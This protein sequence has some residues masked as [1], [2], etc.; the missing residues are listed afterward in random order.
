MGTQLTECVEEI[1][2]GRWPVPLG[3]IF[4][5]Y[6]DVDRGQSI[7]VELVQSYPPWL[8]NSAAVHRACSYVLSGRPKVFIPVQDGDCFGEEDGSI[9]DVHGSTCHDLSV[10]HCLWCLMVLIGVVAIAEE[11]LRSGSVGSV[12]DLGT[13]GKSCQFALFCRSCTHRYCVY[14]FRQPQ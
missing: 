4:E 3:D 8:L 9:V 6:N 7:F 2:L 10:F 14:S 11:E 12:G 1:P 5:W 13:P